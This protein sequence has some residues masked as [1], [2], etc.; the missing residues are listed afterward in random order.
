MTQSR[1]LMGRSSWEFQ[2][3]GFAD[4]GASALFAA[5]DLIRVELLLFA[6]FWFV[7]GAID[8]LALDAAW[9]VL[10]LTGKAQTPRLFEPLSPQLAAPIAL[11]VPTWREA[12]VIGPMVRHTLAAWPHAQLRVYV[13]VYRNDPETARAVR[14]AA[15]GDTRVR[16]VVNGRNGPTTKG[17]CLNAIFRAMRRDEEAERF[18]FRA[19][20]LQDAEDMVHPQGLSL[21]DRGLDTADF[22]QL[23]VRP[24][25]QARSTWI[26]GHY[27]DE[28]TEAHARE[29]VVRD[30]LQAGIPAA[31]VGCAFDRN[32][33]DR[34]VLARD[35]QA[36]GE[37]FTPD[38]MTEDYE[39]GM[40]IGRANRN[41]P[42]RGGRFLRVRAA[43]GSLIATRSPFPHR[44]DAAVR[45]KARWLQGIAFDGWD[46]LGWSMHPAELWMRMRDRRG[47]LVAVVLAVAYMVLLL[48]LVLAVAQWAGWHQQAPLP[49]VIVWML[50]I[51][52]IAFVWRALV[53]F[54]MVSHEYGVLEGVTAVLRIPLANIIA[55]IAARRA[56][57]R[58]IGTL[59]GKPAQWE[60]TEHDYHPSEVKP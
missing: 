6:G 18:R 39:L 22:V 45:Q 60:K 48:S 49:P 35:G 29:M 27:T 2:G 43:D 32:A 59:F 19:V 31:G 41:G 50:V 36:G 23:P 16:L 57:F 42:G 20:I 1:R 21:I 30:R 15:A 44:L 5:L 56:L 55:I 14:L 47:P 24:E 54:A 26:A 25:P 13:G 46:R 34:L 28:F 17:D 9:L 37:P 33:L 8:E 51:T 53:R 52:T 40:T 12:R 10:R 58:Y 11:F 3:M 7:I 38:A 4:G